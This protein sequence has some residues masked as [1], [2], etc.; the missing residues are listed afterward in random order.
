MALGLGALR[1][2]PLPAFRERNNCGQRSVTGGMAGPLAAL[3]AG[4]TPALGVFV[5]GRRGAFAFAGWVCRGALASDA[6]SPPQTRLRV[7]YPA[8]IPRQ[9]ILKLIR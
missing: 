3:G 8:H 1:R 5:A 9:D 2:V 6:V 7:G 4:L